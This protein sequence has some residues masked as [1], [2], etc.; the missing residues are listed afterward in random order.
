MIFEILFF[1]LALCILGAGIKFYIDANKI[2]VSKQIEQS[3]FEKLQ[4]EY[5]K[6]KN[7]DK[8]E[9][10]SLDEDFCCGNM[11]DTTSASLGTALQ[12]LYKNKKESLEKGAFINK[13]KELKEDDTDVASNFD[14]AIQSNVGFG[15][16]DSSSDMS[17]DTSSD[18]NSGMNSNQDDTVD[19]GQDGSNEDSSPSFGDLN[20]GGYGPDNGN[21]EEDSMDMTIPQEQYQIVDVLADKEDNI[22]VKVKNLTSG[23]IEYKDLSEPNKKNKLSK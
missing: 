17:T 21:P 7:K 3:E 1:I 10:S 12:Y 22:R 8:K 23:K 13:L 16:D 19:L 5:D 4:E 18:L 9:E 15:S 6:L 2:I 11:G 14:S 20:I